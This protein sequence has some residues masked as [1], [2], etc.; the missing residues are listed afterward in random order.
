[1]SYVNKLTKQYPISEQ[2]IKAA[3]PN[4]SF[5]NPFV[6][7]DEYA[8]VFPAPQPAYNPITQVVREIT[9]VL[10]V[11]GNY[12]Q[13]YEVIPRF[14]EYTDPEGVV[15]TVA[16]Q[17]AAAQEAILQDKRKAMVVTPWQI[18]KALLA[19]GLLDDVEAAVAAADRVVQLGWVRAQ[20]FKR[21]DPLVVT[22][23]A[24]LGKTDAELDS[25]FELAM[26][27]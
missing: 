19:A 15:H 17:I 25:I 5:A 7:P 22:I 14:V 16:E 23:G 20:D 13:Q 12:E 4:T 1:M 27:L 24:A 21:L 9:P 11:K 18:S 8:L 10:T 26:T 2:E 3:N 6:A